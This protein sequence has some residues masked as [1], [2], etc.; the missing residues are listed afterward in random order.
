V[1]LQLRLCQCD[2]SDSDDLD[3]AAWIAAE[4]ERASAP[5]GADG[6]G[7]VRNLN[8]DTLNDNS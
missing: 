1:G 2:A 6:E 7:D 4:N 8:G 3:W 5:N